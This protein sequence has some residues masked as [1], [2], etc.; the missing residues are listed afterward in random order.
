MRRNA[1]TI[2]LLVW[3]MVVLSCFVVT[4]NWL[5]ARSGIATSAELQKLLNARRYQIDVPEERDGY[6]LTLTPL[7]DGVA[8]PS[9]SAT[10]VGGSRITLLVQN[11]QKPDINY[12]WF[13]GGMTMTGTCTNPFIDAGALTHRSTTHVASGDWLIRGGDNSV[14]MTGP[15]KYE[16]QVNL[17]PPNYGG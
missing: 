9:S 16:L 4:Q 13:G 6:Y 2:F 14:S 15:T 5:D 1:L 7:V 12:A 10:V 17:T 8:K 11:D 3:P